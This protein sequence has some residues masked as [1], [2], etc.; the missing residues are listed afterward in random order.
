METKRQTAKYTEEHRSKYTRGAEQN[1]DVF[2]TAEQ[3]TDVFG[4][5]GAEYGC[6]EPTFAM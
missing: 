5:C 1:T 6:F 3:N 2:G 4:R